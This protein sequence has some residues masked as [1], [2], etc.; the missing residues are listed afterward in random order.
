M[1]DKVKW[2]EADI[3]NL[4][5]E[6]QQSHEIIDQLEFEI[7]EVSSNYGTIYRWATAGNFVGTLIKKSVLNHFFW[8]WPSSIEVFARLFVSSTTLPKNISQ[9]VLPAIYKAYI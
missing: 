6:L 3:K 5:E 9:L 1:A 4:E 2:L 7:E 8:F